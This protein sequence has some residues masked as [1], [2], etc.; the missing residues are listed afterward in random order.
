MTDREDE[1]VQGDERR[2]QA[3]PLEFPDAVGEYRDVGDR[4]ENGRP[5]RRGL[6]WSPNPSETAQ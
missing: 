3:G 6:D 2:E 4:E 5:E 1:K